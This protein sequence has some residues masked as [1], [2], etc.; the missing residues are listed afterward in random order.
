MIAAE[1]RHVMLVSSLHQMNSGRHVVSMT[2]HKEQIERGG[3]EAAEWWHSFCEY[4]E[5]CNVYARLQSDRKKLLFVFGSRYV[6]RIIRSGLYPRVIGSV[7]R[8]DEQKKHE[9]SSH[10]P[11]I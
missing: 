11:V 10:C 1:S 3:S 9:I 4:T 7:S 6:L 2:V 5:L 8:S